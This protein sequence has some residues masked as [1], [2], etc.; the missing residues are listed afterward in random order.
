M[1]PRGEDVPSRTSPTVRRRILAGRL[2]ELRTSANVNRKTAADHLGV[3][4]TT[5]TRIEN[6]SGKASVGDV[7]ALLD[8]YKVEI[9]EER[10][11]LIGLARDA[12][13]RDWFQKHKPVIPARFET[14]FGLEGEAA[15]LRSFELGMVPGLLQ[16]GDYYR[17]YL[18]TPPMAFPLGNIDQMVEFRLAR[19]E[20]MIGA[21]G[22]RLWMILDEAALR[23]PVGGAEVMRAQLAHLQVISQ[24]ENIRVQVYPFSA[25]VHQALDGSFTILEFPER[26]HA[27]VVYLEAQTDSRYLEADDVVDRYNL[28]FNQLAA[29]ALSIEETAAL[30]A[31]TER[32]IR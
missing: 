32:N 10:E 26:S 27:D 13:K 1:T 5:I 9:P 6:T 21:D 7:M 14:Y 2:K 20:R 28:L 22:P 8:L 18:T 15:E 31:E 4:E 23:R 30:L 29:N 25:G 19:Q 11:F 17:A 3:A 16:T 12:S 24:Q